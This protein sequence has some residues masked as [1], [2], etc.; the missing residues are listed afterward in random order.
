MTLFNL[1]NLKVVLGDGFHNYRWCRHCLFYDGD[2]KLCY[3]EPEGQHR[4]P[5]DLACRHFLIDA[6]HIMPDAPHDLGELPEELF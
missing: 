5:D 3:G 6:D 1:R 4:E 2:E